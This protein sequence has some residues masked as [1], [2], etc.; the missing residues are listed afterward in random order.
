[1]SKFKQVAKDYA[2]DRNMSEEQLQE[3]IENGELKSFEENGVLYVQFDDNKVEQPQP[4]RRKYPWIT[5]VFGIIFV[6]IGMHFYSSTPYNISV[7]SVFIGGNLILYAFIIAVAPG[8]K[9]IVTG[10]RGRLLLGSTS[11]CLA[12]FFFIAQP[13][14][15]Y[16]P[17]SYLVTTKSAAGTF[18]HSHESNSDSLNFG[19][20]FGWGAF[21][22]VVTMV[23]FSVKE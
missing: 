23:I 12:L 20:N 17:G 13:I 6:F 1:M 11:F 19:E 21:L 9:E 3:A 22:I 5:I 10:A 16:G 7:V 2:N 15:K 4:H 8:F 18:L 14:Q